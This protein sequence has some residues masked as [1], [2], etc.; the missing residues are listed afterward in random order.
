MEL[1]ITP[2]NKEQEKAIKAFLT[3][4]AIVFHSD[5]EVDAALYKAM[6][7]GRKTKLLNANEKDAF[8]LRLKKAN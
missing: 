2:R 4:L 6:Q 8:L 1:T 7:K 3:S 5:E